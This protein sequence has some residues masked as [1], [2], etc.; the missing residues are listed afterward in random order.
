MKV[1]LVNGSPRAAG[2]TFTALS[3]V[4]KALEE[5]G[6]RVPEDISLMGFE[7]PGISGSALSIGTRAF[8][9]CTALT[10][11]TLPA[12]LSN[13]SLLKYDELRVDTFESVDELM[14]QA[15]D[16]FLGCTNLASINV[17]AN[18]SATYRSEDGVLLSEN[19][20]T[21]AYF[22]AAKSARSY[23]FPA[24]IRAIANGAFFGTSLEGS[25]VIPARITAIG[26]S[27]SCFSAWQT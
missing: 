5:E 9:N 10:S 14:E 2:C 17:A 21:L 16:A 7:N 22:P 24:N 12:R 23:T 4:A 1:L 11:I 19:G 15:N 3:E 8:M 6:W 27:I 25:L 20:R 18:A 26:L 13:I